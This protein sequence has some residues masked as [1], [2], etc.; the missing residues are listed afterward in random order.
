MGARHI[1][2]TRR[3]IFSQ[4]W[5]AR[6]VA[7]NNLPIARS[8]GYHNNLGDLKAMLATYFPEWPITYARPPK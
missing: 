6:F 4:K 8:R 2:I 5:Q 1:V 7:D 3:G